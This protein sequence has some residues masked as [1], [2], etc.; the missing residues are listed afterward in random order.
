MVSRNLLR[1]M[2]FSAAMLASSA[3]ADTV[4]ACGMDRSSLEFAGSPSS[5]AK[6]LLRKVRIGG[7]LQDQ[8]LPQS[9]LDR[10]ENSQGPDLRT[11]NAAIA[12]LPVEA[13][14]HFDRSSNQPVSQ[15]ASGKSAFYFVIHDTSTPYLQDAQFP[16]DL[17]SNPNV[18]N[19]Q[20][21]MRPDAVAHMFVNRAG[22][23]AIGHDFAVPWRATKL[24]TKI[25]GAESRGRFIHVELVQP[26]RRDPAGSLTND[27]V[28]PEPGFSGLQY[29]RLAALY[30]IASRRAGRWLVPAFHAAL[31][32][33]LH[34]AHDD[35]QNFRIED[36]AKSVDLLAQSGVSSD[37]PPPNQAAPQRSNVLKG[38]PIDEAYRQQFASCDTS[39]R[40]GSVQFPIRRGEKIRWYGCSTDPSRFTRFEYFTTQGDKPASVLWEAKL[41]H[42]LDGSPKACNSPGRTDQCRT[43]LMLKPT[44]SHPCPA[45]V[46]DRPYCLPV[47]ADLVPYI[48]IPTAAPPGIDSGAF[49]AKT[50]LRVGD[51]GMVVAN[52]KRIAVLIAD[53]GPAYKIGEGST[54]LLAA[55]SAD[56]NPRTIGAGVVFVAFPGT[57]LQ[58]DV[59]ADQLAAIVNSRAS[60]L[61]ERLVRD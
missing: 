52:G 54:A 41:A 24:E 19:V 49:R 15:T 34:D 14:P 50:G 6:C 26:R 20:R 35:P 27:R 47:N 28:S 37:S 25:L 42:D 40:F 61:Y 10:I 60:E 23:I 48:V 55:L 17:D 45:V 57:S 44:S 36:F 8:E 29:S 12:T 18:N 38:T 4:G 43:T 46:R 2:V 56:G 9:L 13:R 16:I 31:D 32:A 7:I 39:D 59:D 21:Y 22:S 1:A 51:L 11:M 33:G 3:D 30:V 5:Q 58:A 53:T